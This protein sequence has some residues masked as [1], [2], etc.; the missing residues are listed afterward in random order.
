[1]V[2]RQKK[3]RRDDPLLRYLH[4]ARNS[5]EHG[6][7]RVVQSTGFNRHPFERRPLLVNER[8][9]LRAE[10][11]NQITL[12]PAPDSLTADVIAAGPTLRPM[13]ARDERYHDYCD[14]P[15]THLGIPIEFPDFADSLASAALPYLRDMVADAEAF[16][17]GSSNVIAK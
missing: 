4:Y 10:Q 17:P 11:L 1:M 9:P 6:I 5:N 16:L 7:E 14:P 13:R 15:E 8:I 2:W 12:E 3:E